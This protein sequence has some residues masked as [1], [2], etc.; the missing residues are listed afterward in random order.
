MVIGLLRQ[1]AF[2]LVWW[3]ALASRIGNWVLVVALHVYLYEQ[4]GSPLA[5]SGVF[6]AYYLPGLLFGSLAGVFADRWDRKRTMVAANLGQAAAVLFLLLVRSPDLLWLAYVVAFVDAGLAQLFIPAENALMPRLVPQQRLGPANALHS[7]NDHL[8]RTVGPAVAGVVVALAGLHGAAVLDSASFLL[9]AALIAL[10]RREDLVGG[11]PPSELVPVEPTPTG[12]RSELV[13]GLRTIARNPTLWRLFLLAAIASLA[14]SF[15]QTLLVPFVVDVIGAGPEA[16]GAALGIRGAAGLVGGI[17][18]AYLAAFLPLSRLLAGSLL[19]CAAAF[20]LQTASPT[21][22]ALFG[23]MALIGPAFVAW[24]TSQRT[25][26]QQAASDTHRGRVFGTYSNANAAVVL[27]G[28]T[29]AGALAEFV[30][31][32]P[33][34]AASAA[35]FGLGGCLALFGL[36]PRTRPSRGVAA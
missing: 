15:F 23:A 10:V 32:V 7:V 33:V 5:V 31:I 12:I 11:A 2:G 16:V 18:V 14:W 36:V 4:T 35:L 3:A 29:S 1:R 17:V 21:L 34:L 27:I 25:L 13:D 30:G 22:V 6:V 26:M 24:G 28:N 20:L 19:V 8:A 9:S